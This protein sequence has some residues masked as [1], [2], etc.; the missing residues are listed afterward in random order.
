MPQEHNERL[1]RNNQGMAQLLYT[2]R[3]EQA[4]AAASSRLHEVQIHCVTLH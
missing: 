1:K 2:V 3:L 4:L